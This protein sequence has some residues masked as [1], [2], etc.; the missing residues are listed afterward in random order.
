MIRLVRNQYL[1]QRY[2]HHC[3]IFRT[4]KGNKSQNSRNLQILY[5]CN[6][7]VR[8]QIGGF[9]L[10]CFW[11][12]FVWVELCTVQFDIR[13]LVSLFIFYFMC[14]KRFTEKCKQILSKL[15]KFILNTSWTKFY[16][17]LTNIKLFLI[18]DA[19]RSFLNRIVCKYYF[20]DN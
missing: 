10:L 13:C 16:V 3:Q 12:D 1:Q 7:R 9:L 8:L 2:N 17:Q 19:K 6:N 18:L 11:F 14:R 20:F 5:L 4:M 15:I